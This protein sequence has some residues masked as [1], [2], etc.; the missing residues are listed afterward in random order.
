LLDPNAP[1]QNEASVSA[2]AS[3]GYFFNFISEGS[4]YQIEFNANLTAVGASRLVRLAAGNMTYSS[5]LSLGL[6]GGGDLSVAFAHNEKSNGTAVVSNH[7]S[8][9]KRKAL[10]QKPLTPLW[11]RFAAGNSKTPDLKPQE[12]ANNSL[13]I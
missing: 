8:E 4:S 3:G 6:E 2:S 12:Q 11:A 10:A 13:R 7:F 5:P 9:S 1:D